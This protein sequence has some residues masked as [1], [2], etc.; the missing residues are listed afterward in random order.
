VI[1]AVLAVVEQVAVV[2]VVV[3]KSMLV[4]KLNQKQIKQLHSLYLQE[5]W[6]KDRTLTQTQKVVENSSLILGITDKDDNLI[7]FSRVLSDFTFKAFIFDVIVA[8]EH[9]GEGL[10]DKL[11]STILNHSKL[12]NIET[13]ELY[14]LPE[15]KPLYTKYGFK[16]VD[17]LCFLTRI[18]H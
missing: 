4:E 9:R 8:K 14:C 15:M 3:H 1:L 13:I 12:K 7:A 17:G 5:W 10:S 18:M 6:C 11:L 16:E 2:A